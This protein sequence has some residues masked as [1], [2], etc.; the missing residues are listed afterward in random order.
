MSGKRKGLYL[1]ALWE[2]ANLYPTFQ[3]T[4]AMGDFEIAAR[5]AWKE[6]YPKFK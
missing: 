1:A 6:I 2:L 5:A 4:F 3:P